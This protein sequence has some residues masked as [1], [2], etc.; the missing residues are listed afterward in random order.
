[1]IVRRK[2]SSLVVAALGAT[3]LALTS[4]A[5]FSAT[6]VS[7]QIASP[8]A[9]R[10][11]KNKQN[12]SPMVVSPFNANVVVSGANDEVEQPD[13]TPLTGGSSSCP[14]DPNT[15]GTGMYVSTD[16]GTSY[17][18]TMLRWN[19]S[20][21]ISDGDPVVAFGPRPGGVSNAAGGRL[22]AGSLAG[23]PAFGPD[24]EQVAV[25]WS[26]DAGVT[27]SQPRLVSSRDGTVNFNDKI[28]LW[29]DAGPVSPH[30]GNV[31]V[32]WTLFT[33]SGS[34]GAANTFSPEPIM[35]SRSTDFGAHWSRAQKISQFSRNNGSVGGRQGAQ[36]RTGP[37]GAV[38]VFWDDAVDKQSV[39]IAAKSTD[40]GVTFGRPRVIAAKLDNP[41]PF[42]GARFRD[43]SFPSA[44]V[45]GTGAI[46][47]TWTS[48]LSGHGVVRVAR[49][50][51]GGATWVVS[52]IADVAGRSPYFPAV[53]AS[54]DGTKVLIGFNTVTDKPAGT[55]PGIGVVSIDARY[56]VSTDGGASFGAPSLIRA[57]GDPE[58]S[59][60]NALGGQFLGDYNGAAATN[61]TA[62]FAFTD[63]SAGATCAAVSAFRD[64][65]GPKPNIY[66]SC[67]NAF[68]DTDI[69]V[70]KITF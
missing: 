55:K 52:T 70:A 47:V 21:L 12:E 68:G 24:Q 51:N 48:Y 25:A 30:R 57:S 61:T 38:Y 8:S 66:D 19:A 4:Q 20:G 60:T 46:V 17:A 65:T 9:T 7:D 31:Y 10:F 35:F 3:V 23:S 69:R 33:G 44:D 58:A 28:A 50:V 11:P 37:N 49:S 64:G 26:D 67:S 18:R 15:N 41:S 45:A 36:I 63:A 42:P 56:V 1:M 54:P 2:S 59:S 6:L 5:V 39:I 40:G 16:G 29:A 62:W 32:A 14:F 43:N 13:C 34:F 53:A 22:Y 27:F